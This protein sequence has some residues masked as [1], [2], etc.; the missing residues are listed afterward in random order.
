MFGKSVEP[1]H[2]AGDVYKAQKPNV[3]LIKAG[4]H[5]A[6]DLYALKKILNQMARIAAVWTR[7]VI[8]RVFKKMKTIVLGNL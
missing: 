3:K 6:K 1:L 8:S 7:W 5:T 2:D 4:G